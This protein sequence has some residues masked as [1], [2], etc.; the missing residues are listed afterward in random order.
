M[1]HAIDDADYAESGSAALWLTPQLQVAC[2]GSP[3]GPRF[4]ATGA[5]LSW[6]AVR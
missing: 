1:E 4:V 5:L 6:D 2:D 3:F